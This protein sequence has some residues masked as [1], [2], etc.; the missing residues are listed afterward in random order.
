MCDFRC[1]TICIFQWKLIEFC[2]NLHDLIVWWIFFKSIHLHNLSLGGIEIIIKVVCPTKR[3]KK[4]FEEWFQIYKLG[5]SIRQIL[6]I[7]KM[8]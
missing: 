7:N 4:D 5:W 6:I 8:K 1:L 3:E 2:C